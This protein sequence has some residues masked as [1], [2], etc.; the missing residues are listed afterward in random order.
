MGKDASVLF[1]QHRKACACT[2]FFLAG[3]RN[4]SGFHRSVT[5]MSDLNP[6][7]CHK[8]KMFACQY[9]HLV[10][11]MSCRAWCENHGVMSLT[12][13]SA[14]VLYYMEFTTS[15]MCALAFVKMVKAG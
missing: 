9:S 5:Y 10:L 4:M 12:M 15:Q 11:H 2:Y 1:E 7:G 8:L 14:C 13:R 6:C 3:N